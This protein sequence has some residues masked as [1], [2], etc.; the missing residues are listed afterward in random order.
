[1]ATRGF[2][3]GDVFQNAPML[4]RDFQRGV[5]VR[6]RA[7]PVAA[8][9]GQLAELH[10]SPD[11]EVRIRHALL[12]DNIERCFEV[13]A[14][15][16]ESSAHRR[17]SRQSGLGRGAAIIEPRHLG[18]R[19]R[20]VVE[21]AEFELRVAEHLPREAFARHQFAQLFRGRARLCETML[22]ERD[23][24]ARREPGGILIRGHRL[25]RLRCR[26]VGAAQILEIAGPPL[27]AQIAI[28]EQIPRD[29]VGG[30][31]GNALFQR[32]DAAIPTIEQRVRAARQERR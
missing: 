32:G 19:L 26:A 15:L 22:R 24:R 10:T 8:L 12:F 17:E 9:E 4:G 5:K 25:E 2:Q 13:L 11:D 18:V 1:M 6:I 28:D 27:A 21:V 16:V 7:V 14:S 31:G 30:V 3:F 23:S 29:E 20:R